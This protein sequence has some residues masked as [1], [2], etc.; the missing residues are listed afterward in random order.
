[1]QRAPQLCSPQGP[2]RRGGL[3]LAF[4]AA[5]LIA[6]ALPARAELYRCPQPGGGV[7]FTDDP[8]ACPGAAAIQPEDR[9]QRVSEPEAAGAGP[10]SSQRSAAAKADPHADEA[11]AGVWRGR[12]QRAQAEL[13]EATREREQLEQYVTHC[14]HGRD[15]FTRLE[16]GLKTSVSCDGV[17]ERHAALAR[18]VAQLERFLSE[19]LEEECRRSGCEPGWL[20]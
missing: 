5:L 4:A 19:Q 9:I 12:K 15:L 14:N 20:R 17:R 3:A 1:M 7:S 8:S 2:R 16:N 10:R 6:C 18:R 11:E 13:R